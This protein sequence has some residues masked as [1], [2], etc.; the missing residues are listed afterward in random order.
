MNDPFD[1]ELKPNTWNFVLGLLIRRICHLWSTSWIWL[2]GGVARDPRSAA[3]K[4][5]LAPHIQE[6]WNSLPQ[7]DIQNL[8]AS[9]LRR[10]AVL[11]AARGGYTKN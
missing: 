5:E 1:Y 6:I 8:F 4:D 3:S 11:T 9:V 2:V 10:I 7:T